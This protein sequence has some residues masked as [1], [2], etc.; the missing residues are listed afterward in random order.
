MNDQG[1]RLRADWDGAAEGAPYQHDGRGVPTT[2]MV[3]L[4][5]LA[6]EDSVLRRWHPY[7]AHFTFGLCARAWHVQRA[8][9]LAPLGITAWHGEYL[10]WDFAPYVYQ[11]HE[12]PI[13]VTQ[14]PA[15]AVR[16]ASELL[17][18]LR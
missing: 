6:R 9:H 18:K 4:V 17:A 7:F 5:R 11:G 16:A 13:L 2:L 14:D 15:A 12:D 8:K 3:D 10:V 1:D